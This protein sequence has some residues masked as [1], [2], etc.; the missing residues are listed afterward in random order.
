MQIQKL[1]AEL[2]HALFERRGKRLVLTEA[3]RIALDHADAI[4]ARGADLVNALGEGGRE[5]R[6]LRVGSLATLSRNFQLQFLK[7]LFKRD[8][9]EIV[10]RSGGFADMLRALEAHLIDVLLAN[11]AP[12]RDAATPWVAHPIA[13][14]AVSLVGHPTRKKRPKSLMALLAS[15]PLVLPAAE[16]SIRAG[17]DALVDRLG[18]RPRIAAEVDDM[19]MLRLLARERIGLAVVPSIVVQ[20]E[21]RAGVLVEIAPLPLVETFFAITLARRLPN[22][23]LKSLI[24]ESDDDADTRGRRA[25][26]AT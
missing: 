8:D 16:S 17:F 23:L 13:K 18:V 20:D 11:V 25:R 22:P 4:F 6:V 10:V 3:G 9:V 1:E 21:L 2:G 5:R 19:A 14:Q 26:S 12:T 15:E 24:R 7:P